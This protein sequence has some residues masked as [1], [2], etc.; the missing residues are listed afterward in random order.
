MEHLSGIVEDKNSNQCN[1]NNL[2]K[3]SKMTQYEICKEQS[4]STPFSSISSFLVYL[5]GLCFAPKKIVE[6]FNV[7]IRHFLL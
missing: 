3:D 1:E 5:T 7:E 2:K 6:F 4:D